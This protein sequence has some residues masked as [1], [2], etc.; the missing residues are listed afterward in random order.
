MSS[1]YW[2][3]VEYVDVTSY[4]QQGHIKILSDG[5]QIFVPPKDYDLSDG[6]K[7]SDWKDVISVHYI[8]NEMARVNLPRV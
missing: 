1:P 7:L 5:R 2:K 8:L 3:Y 4:M 6:S